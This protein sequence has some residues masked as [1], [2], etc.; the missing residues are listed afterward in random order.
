MLSFLIVV[1]IALYI[2][3]MDVLMSAAVYWFLILKTQIPVDSNY[4]WL[5]ACI[6][7]SSINIT[8][9]VFAIT[10]KMSSKKN[11]KDPEKPC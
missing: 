7:A 8:M 5:S 10:G 3:F 9:A 1:V 2:M 11:S 6:F 4:L